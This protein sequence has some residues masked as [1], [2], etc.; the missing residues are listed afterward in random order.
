[1]FSWYDRMDI[2][3]PT[4]ELVVATHVHEPNGGDHYKDH[5]NYKFIGYANNF[6]SMYHVS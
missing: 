6:L 4:G 5:Y 3:V 2:L 1:M